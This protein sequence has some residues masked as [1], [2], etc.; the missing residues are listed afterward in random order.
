M[1][2]PAHSTLNTMLKLT[3]GVLVL[4]AAASFNMERIMPIV[5]DASVS[6]QT[7]TFFD[8][9]ADLVAGA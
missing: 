4:L 1:P 9:I 3:A 8:R 5:H 6:L 7:T 2:E